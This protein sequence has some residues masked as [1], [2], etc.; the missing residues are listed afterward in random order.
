MGR[1]LPDRPDRRPRVLRRRRAALHDALPAR[2]LRLRP[3]ARPL[4]R[5]RRRLRAADA[6]RV[7]A[8]PARPGRHRRRRAAADGAAP[9]ESR[10]SAAEP[11]TTRRSRAEAGDGRQGRPHRRRRA[12]RASSPSASSRA[13]AR[14]SPST[15]R[16]ATTTASSCRRAQDFATPTYAIV[17]ESAELDTGGAEWALDTFLGTVRDPER[18]RP[19]ACSSAS[20]RPPTVDRYLGGVEHDVVDDLDTSGDPEYSRPSGQRALRPARRRRRSGPRRVGAGR[21]D[22]RLGARGRRLARR[23]DERRRVARSVRRT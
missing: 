9:V 17:S 18:E 23:R 11:P 20:G 22:A 5:A 14:S 3:R 7:P 16:S 13:D 8:V 1:R 6:R 2:D 19:S 12:S 15:R 21:A 4:G 10:R